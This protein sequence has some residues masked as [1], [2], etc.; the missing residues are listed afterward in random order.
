LTTVAQLSEHVVRVLGQNPGKFT[1]QGTNTYLIGRANPYILLDTGEGHPAY[2]PLLRTALADPAH[3]HLPDVSDIILTHHHADHVGGLPSP[4][5]FTP[6]PSDGGPFHALHS[7]QILTGPTPSSQTLSILHTPGHTPDSIALLYAPDRAL[8]TADTVLGQG[9]A[10]FEDLRLYLS[11]LE[12][13]RGAGAAYDVLYPAHGPVV[14]D[15]ARTIGMY[16]AH[17]LEREAQ[18]VGALRGAP[19]EGAEAWSTWALVGRLYAQYPPSLW[20]PAAGGLTLHLRK[21]VE[22]GRARA[23]GGEGKDATWVL[24]E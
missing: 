10:V 17:R 19:P 21:L 18:V 22:E 6:S 14:R 16:V 24:V 11:S 7:D 5:T 23:V 8:F 15:G 2:P 3:P 9:T 4:G 13:M 12:R 20:E 1:L